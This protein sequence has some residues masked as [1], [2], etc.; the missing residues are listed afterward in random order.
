MRL[1]HKVV[2]SIANTDVGV[3]CHVSLLDLY[4][5]K[6][7][8]RKIFFIADPVPT[9]PV[10]TDKPWYRSVVIGRNTLTKMVS[11][12]CEEAGISGQKTNHSLRVSCSSMQEYME[13]YSRTYWSSLVR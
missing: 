13:N 2:T 10:E 1:E 11:L 12:M 5:S 3:R 9:A 8:Y 6:L 7:L 4:I